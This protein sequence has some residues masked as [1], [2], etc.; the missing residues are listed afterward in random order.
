MSWSVTKSSDN[1]EE[2]KNAVENDPNVPSSVRS[3]CTLL[4]NACPDGR[5]LNLNTSGHHENEQLSNVSI[6]IS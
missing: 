1:K 4:I 5:T 2:L 3:A 6:S